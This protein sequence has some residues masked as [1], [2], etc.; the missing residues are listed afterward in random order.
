[1]Q[2]KIIIGDYQQLKKECNLIRHHVFVMEQNVPIELELDDRDTVSTHLL[3]QLNDDYIGTGRIDLEKQGK[4]G[5]LAV[6]PSFRKQG[7]GKI[8]LDNL[9]LIAREN[10]LNSV[11]LNAQKQSLNFYLKSGYTIASDEFWEANIIHLKMMKCLS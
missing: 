11:W 1:M 10:Q 8:I 2:P 9:E 4:I 7:Y 6:L 3:L 5:R